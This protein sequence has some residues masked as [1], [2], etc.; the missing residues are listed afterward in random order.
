MLEDPISV[1]EEDLATKARSFIRDEGLR[2]LVVLDDNNN[3]SGLI[4]RSNVLKIKNTKSDVPAK[5][6]AEEPMVYLYDDMDLRTASRKIIEHGVDDAPVFDQEKKFLGLLGREDIL[7]GLKLKGRSPR[8]DKV[9]D[10]TQNSETVNPGTSITK[11]WNRMERKN[12]Q[13]F[14]VVREVK[15]KTKLE[16]LIS[17][18]DLV[19][20]RKF[21]LDMDQPPK[22]ERVMNRSPTVLHSDDSVGEAVDLIIEKDQ[23]II[24]VVRND[25]VLKGSINKISLIKGFYS[26]L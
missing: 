19:S 13:A 7:K 21:S 10:F 2:T 4:K 14:P 17:Q 6:L 9:K 16:G 11:I 1:E 20:H 12:I 24:P 22:I 26:S 18:Q 25:Y 15:G 23:G 3:L 5:S 8:S